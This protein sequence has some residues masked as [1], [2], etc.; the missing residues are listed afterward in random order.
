MKSRFGIK[1]NI[2]EQIVNFVQRAKQSSK[3]LETLLKDSHWQI[4]IHIDHDIKS[5][6]ATY[7]YIIHS[8]I[9]IL[10]KI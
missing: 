2:V 3:Y 8:H 1:A 7:R 9:S 4:Q 5:T 10:I 6:N